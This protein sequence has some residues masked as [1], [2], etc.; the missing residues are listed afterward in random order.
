M[1]SPKD[2][3][4]IHCHAAGVGAGGSGCFLSPSLRRSARYR[5]YLKAFGLDERDLLREGDA[6]VLDRVAA[7]LRSSLRVSAAVV[8][9]LDGVV[10]AS[11]NLDV[12]ETEIYVPNDFVLAGVGRHS[13]LLFGASINPR[14]ENA[15]ELLEE[16]AARG[17]VLVKWLPPIQRIDPA[18]RHHVPFYEKLAELRLPLLTHTGTER[19]FTSH[20]DEL[21]APERLRLPL[22][23]GV[24]VIAAHAG[25]NGKTGRERNIDAFVRLCGEFPNLYGDISASTLL[26]SLGNL[27]RLLRGNIRERL[28]YGSDMPLPNTR[29]VTPLAFPFRLTLRR[30]AAIS[31]TANPW[32]RDVAL[33]EALGVTPDILVNA[34][35]LLG[36]EAKAQ[37]IPENPERTWQ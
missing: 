12:G 21:G 3:L 10:D 33:K 27:P 4:D 1:E 15:L 36:R 5:F 18:D 24:T 31:R 32:D 22:D 35:R 26:N 28:L 9:A 11:G 8:L 30:I 37:L 14:R 17:A 29:L 7:M 19:S 16:A 25:G 13:N 20:R 23:V 2:I 6:L 34:S